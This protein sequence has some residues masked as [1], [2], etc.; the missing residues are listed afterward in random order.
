MPA[1]SILPWRVAGNV[2]GTEAG[3]ADGL[4][5]IVAGALEGPA[6]AK[7]WDAD[8]AFVKEMRAIVS[9]PFV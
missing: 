3:E 2:L 1:E 6:E 7:K 4:R 9:E 5:L 8:I